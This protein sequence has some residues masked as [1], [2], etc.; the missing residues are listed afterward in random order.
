MF[1]SNIMWLE[2]SVV[3]GQKD[4]REVKRAEINFGPKGD[5]V[6]MVYAI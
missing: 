4:G 1:K 2:T 3:I 5:L 6:K